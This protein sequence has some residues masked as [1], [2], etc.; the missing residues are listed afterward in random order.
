MRLTLPIPSL[1]NLTNFGQ[2]TADFDLEPY[3]LCW[4]VDKSFKSSR[5]VNKSRT[6]WL[7]IYLQTLT[8]FEK[9]NSSIFFII[10][11]LCHLLSV[12]PYSPNSTNVLFKK[13]FYRSGAIEKIVKVNSA[14]R[15]FQRFCQL[16]ALL[17]TQIPVLLIKM[18]CFAG[19][20]KPE[21]EFY[22][23]SFDLMYCFSLDQSLNL[24]IFSSMVCSL[25]FGRI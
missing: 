23:I 1:Y 24:T 20:T 13:M 2:V 25:S 12:W 21:F 16:R 17:F 22:F 14:N 10:C 9:R 4:T 18:S 15:F 11:H 3:S 7:S 5:S 8:L 6:D 19:T